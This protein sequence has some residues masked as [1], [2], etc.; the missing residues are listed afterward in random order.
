MVTVRSVIALAVSKGW[1]MYQIDVYNAF[2][3]GDLDE[4]VYMEMPN[5]FKEGRQ[6]KV[7][8]LIKSLY[9]LKQAS[10]QWNIKLTAALLSAGFTQSS[11]DYSLFTLK[12]SEGMV[13]ILVYIDDIL[14]TGDNTDMINAAKG[15]LDKRFKLKD[16]GLAGAKA[17]TTPLETN[18]KLTSVEVDEATGVKGD[19]ILR[20]TTS[21]QRLVG[22]LMYATITRLDISYAVQ[23]LSQFM[24][25]PKKSHL[26]A[27]NRVIR[28][29]K[30]TVGQG[31]W[32]KSQPTAELVC[33]CD[34]DWAACPNTRRSVTGYVVQFGSSLISWKSKKQHS[35]SR[36]SAEAEYRSM[37]SALAEVTWLEVFQG[38]MAYASVASLMRTM[39]VVLASKL[40][41]RSVI[42]D[43]EEEFVALHKKVSFFEIFLKNFEKNKTS[44]KMTD[45]EGQ[46]KELATVVEQIIQQRLTEIVTADNVLQREKIHD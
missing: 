28:Y 31:I 17:A 32:L 13:V 30:G 41:M 10:R 42:S 14:I 2:L 29:L 4:E 3:Q 33:W 40:P 24:Q 38:D 22:K 20:D 46:I 6:H 18:A 15:T 36:S 19:A 45:L 39:G 43:H 37:A 5:G 23:T 8:K 44:G 26:E 34:S 9:G 27:A 16:L 7:C 35:V 11:Y 25:Q 21:Y 12:K 1:C